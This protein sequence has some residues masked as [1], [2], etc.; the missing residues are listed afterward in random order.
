M[1]L[2]EGREQILLPSPSS[3]ET[4][5]DA[6]SCFLSPAL[7]GPAPS[8]CCSLSLAASAERSLPVDCSAR[9]AASAA[10][11]CPA[12]ESISMTL[13]PSLACNEEWGEMG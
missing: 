12:S 1:A 7:A 4:P 11:L 10:S 8:L 6:W 9:F 5:D 3:T 13:S 2:A